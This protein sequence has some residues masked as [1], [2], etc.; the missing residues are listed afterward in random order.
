MMCLDNGA[1]DESNRMY[2]SSYASSG[3]AE[4]YPNGQIRQVVPQNLVG[5]YGVT[6]DFGGTVHAADHYRLGDDLA[7]FS[8]GIVAD[9]DQLHITSQYGEVRTNQ[10]V[11]AR[12]L[13]RPVGI[14]VRDDGALVVA[15]AG[16]GRVIA[17]EADDTITVVASGFGSPVDVAFD[18]QQRCYVSDEL[19]VI[20]R[21]DDG[22]AVAI[23]SGLATPQGLTVRGEELFVVEVGHQ[24]VL[25]IHLDTGERRVEADNLAIS[26]PEKTA[27]ALFAHGMPGCPGQFAGIAVG[28]DGSLHVA[29]EGSVLR[30]SREDS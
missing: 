11:R 30:I 3:I 5:P 21:I 22:Q 1:F 29:G 6:V 7:I 18:A 17:I 20:Y 10:R 19:G 12:E 15:E 8:H 28:P 26:P 13:D 4:V 23:A 27:R 9:Q 16:A 24:R 25:A 14:A 2:V